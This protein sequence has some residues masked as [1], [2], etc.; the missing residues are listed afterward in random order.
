MPPGVEPSG[1]GQWIGDRAGVQIFVERQGP[2]TIGIGRGE[3]FRRQPSA[4]F[5][6]IERAVMIGIELCE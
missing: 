4:Q 1:T 3:L 2:V 6:R 5:A